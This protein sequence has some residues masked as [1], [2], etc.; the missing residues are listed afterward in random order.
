MVPTPRTPA[1]AVDAL[2]VDPTRGVVLIR[3]ANPPFQGRW[4]LPGGF[5]EIGETCEAACVREARE[6]TGL[7]V[8]PVELV[9]CCR[10]RRLRK[11]QARTDPKPAATCAEVLACFVVVILVPGT[12]AEPVTPS[13]LPH[14]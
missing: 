10:L 9:G 12:I 13:P 6:E 8:E 11:R 2:I 3:R 5:V 1:I 4:A 14:W 7:E